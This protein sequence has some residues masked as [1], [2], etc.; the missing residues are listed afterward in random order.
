MR[1]RAVSEVKALIYISAY[2]FVVFSA[3]SFYKSSILQAAGVHWLPW[4][5][6]LVKSLILAKFVLIGRALH[7]AEG[8]RTK[9]LIWQILHKWVSFLILAAG[10]TVI[11]EA[12]V[13]LI[14]GKTIEASIAEVG[15]GTT[16]EMIAT[17]ILMFLVFLPLFAYGALGEVV[18]DKALFKT[19]FVT[20]L[21]FEVA[22]QKR[23][24]SSSP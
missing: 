1:D 19:L 9:P 3:L 16:E 6:A 10:F 14:H 23:T 2:L 22:D 7:I 12:S 18:G 24:E 4:G 15:G 8:H 20:R 17:A 13:G 5:F 21:E 11:E